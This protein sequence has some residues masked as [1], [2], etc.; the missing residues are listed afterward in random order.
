MKDQETTATE[1]SK[2]DNQLKEFTGYKLDIK[3]HLEDSLVHNGE[4]MY[5]QGEAEPMVL[6]Q[7]TIGKITGVI[8]NALRSSE[9]HRKHTEGF[10][11][12]KSD[13]DLIIEQ[14][15][16]FYDQFI[17][18]Y[19]IPKIPAFI[20]SYLDKALRASIRPGIYMI[21]ARLGWVDVQQMRM[22]MKNSQEQKTV[23]GKVVKSELSTGKSKNGFV[24]LADPMPKERG[25]D[26]PPPVEAKPEG[27]T[28]EP[29]VNHPKR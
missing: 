26:Q 6:Q 21:V 1:E 10:A 9:F 24:E 15:E 28:I 3:K 14:A 2:S 11:I 4:F 19:D 8:E 23:E 20:E 12:S 17:E 22:K 5:I 7:Q 29:R 25:V 18:P 16:A 13:I 27:K